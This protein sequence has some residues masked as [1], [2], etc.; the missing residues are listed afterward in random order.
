MLARLAV[1]GAAVTTV[2]DRDVGRRNRRVE[3]MTKSLMMKI[4]LFLFHFSI[5]KS[6][7]VY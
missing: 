3:A 7:I 4:T 5:E 1:R 2:V 6:I